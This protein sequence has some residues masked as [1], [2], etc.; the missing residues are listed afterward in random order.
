MT[1]SASILGS[2]AIAALI[3]AI[4]VSTIANGAPA[5]STPE[6]QATTEALNR[7]IAEGNIAVE[8]KTKAD[9][10]HTRNR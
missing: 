6:E 8:A 2:A 1:R 10:A 4:A 7:K 5:P 3:G 9:Q